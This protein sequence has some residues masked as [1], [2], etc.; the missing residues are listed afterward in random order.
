[1]PRPYSTEIRGKSPAQ[2]N[3]EIIEALARRS[4]PQEHTRTQGYAYNAK[5]SRIRSGHPADPTISHLQRHRSSHSSIT[6]GVV[7][8]I[9]GNYGHGHGW[10]DVTAETSRD[11]TLARLREYRDNEPGTPFR[12]IRRREPEERKPR[13][14]PNV[15]GSST[16]AKQAHANRA[17]QTPTTHASGLE[18]YRKL[19]EKAIKRCAK[20]PRQNHSLFECVFREVHEGAPFQTPQMRRLLEKAVHAARPASRHH[21]TKLGPHDAKQ[22]LKAA[23]IDFSSDLHQLSSSQKQLIVDAARAAGYRKRKDAPGSTARMYFQYLSRIR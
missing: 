13:R 18:A 14:K 22:R 6:P 23:G 3:R 2:L 9:Q 20:H 8:V 12:R 5:A 15:K 17:Q 10:E 19:V 4:S 7:H 16:H 1:M 21:A 11:E